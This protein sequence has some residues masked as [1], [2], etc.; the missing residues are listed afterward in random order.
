MSLNT[1]NFDNVN[2]SSFFNYNEAVNFINSLNK[3]NSDDDCPYDSICISNNCI[4]TFYCQNND[5]CAFYETLCN[6]KPCKKDIPDKVLMPCTS[7]NDCLSN[8][9]IKDNNT[10]Q[11]L[12]DYTSGTFTFNDAY[13]YYKKFSHCNGDNECPNQS[14]CSANECVSS[15]Y[16]KLNDDK[17]CAFNENI[18]DGISYEKGRECKVNEDCLSSICDNGKCERNNYALVSKRTKLFGLEQG[19]KCTNNNEC[20]TKYCN[21]EGICGPFQNLSGVIYILFGFFILVIIITGICICCCCRLCK[22]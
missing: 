7:D 3:C 21:D 13:N 11:R 19:E 16:C 20:S 4:V 9:C 15:F 10:C 6:G 5:K 22:K 2:P 12:I 14:S 17:V 1:T 8:V 18:K